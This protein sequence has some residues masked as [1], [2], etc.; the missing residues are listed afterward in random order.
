MA[1]KEA[2]EQAAKWKNGKWY[3]RTINGN[4][5]RFRLENFSA[6]VVDKFNEAL[7]RGVMKEAQLL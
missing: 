1:S 5:V 7:A 3:T 2:I 6:D 4:R